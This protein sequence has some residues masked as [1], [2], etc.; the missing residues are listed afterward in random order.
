MKS[1]VVV[2]SGG[3]TD[4]LMLPTNAIARLRQF[5]RCH[6][7]SKSVT[8]NDLERRNG[9]YRPAALFHL[10]WHLLGANYVTTIKVRL[11]CLQQKCNPKNLVSA[12]M[13]C[14]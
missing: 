12:A 2:D 9:R 11:Y 13:T 3:Q 5:V 7:F 4:L 14:Y 6:A 8:L 10:I 1:V